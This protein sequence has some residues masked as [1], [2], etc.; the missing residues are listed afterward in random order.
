ML[1]LASL[2]S[3]ARCS[4][5]RIVLVMRH[6]R[7]LYQIEELLL[8]MHIELPVDVVDMRFSCRVRNAEFLL[9]ET[10]VPAT[11]EVSQNLVLTG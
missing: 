6:L 10:R 7:M 2:A 5:F 4:L 11:C 3:L 8:R 1:R 9:D